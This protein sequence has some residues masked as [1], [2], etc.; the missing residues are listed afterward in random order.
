MSSYSVYEKLRNDRNLNDTQ[1]AK[2]AGIPRAAIGDWKFGRSQPKIDK[3][4]KIA[5]VLGVHVS[6]LIGDGME[7]TASMVQ[8]SY[9]S[10]LKN[11]E[12]GIYI[13]SDIIE[14]A[15]AA[16]D[17]P[18]RKKLFKLSSKVEPRDLELVCQ[19]LERFVG[20]DSN[21]NE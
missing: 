3:L 5:K 18:M 11:V 19:L 20:K 10:I 8:E 12:N 13:D 1:V 16:K 2:A 6:A 9:D 21:E 4:Q 14:Y 17:A 15:R 7:E